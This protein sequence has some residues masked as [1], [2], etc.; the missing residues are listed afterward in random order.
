[1]GGC[2]WGCGENI[3]ELMCCVEDGIECVAEQLVASEEGLFCMA[4]IV[5][6][7]NDFDSYIGGNTYSS[8]SIIGFDES[9]YHSLS[10]QTSH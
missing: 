6:H 8:Y 7:S 9:V 4:L 2:E 10:L 1:M 3:N 5:V